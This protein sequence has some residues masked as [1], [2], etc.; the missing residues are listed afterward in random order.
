MTEPMDAPVSTKI[1]EFLANGRR[2]RQ[3]QNRLAAL[4]AF[5]AAAEIDPGDAV[6]KTELAV[7][8]HALDWLDEADAVLDSVLAAE[9][10]CVG[11]LIERGHLRRRRGDYEAAAAAFRAA[12]MA[13][14]NNKNIQVELARALR[15]LERLD[16]AGRI[17]S[18]LLNAEPRH[19][20]AL[21][22]RGHLLRKQDDQEGAAAAFAAAAATDPDNRNIAVELARALR[23]LDRIAEADAVLDRVLEAEPNN[24]GAL[25]ERAHTLR[26]R[27]DHYAAASAFEAAAAI[28]PHRNIQVELARELRAL[29]HLDAAEAALRSVVEAEPSHAGGWMELAQVCRSR[30][31]SAGMLAAL[32][33]A[34]KAAPANLDVK[35]ALASEYGNHNRADEALRVFEDILVSNPSHVATLM[36][37]GQLHRSR[38]D[39]LKAKA[40][41]RTVLEVQP[42]HTRALVE[43][44]HTSWA[45]GEPASAQALLLR[46][47]SQ[48]P[49]CLD[50]IIASAELAL[51][52]GDAASALQSARRAIELYPGQIGPYLLGARA[53]A[54]LLDRDE[55]EG[56]LDQ[57]RAAFGFRSEIAAAQ[58]HILRQY[59]CYDPVRAI[60]A[61]ADKQAPVNFGL[62]M[63]VISFAIAQGD[64]DTA[65]Q[66]LSSVSA[67]SS[68]ET[69]RVLYL[70]ASL[71][72]ARRQ[73]H[74]AVADYEAA[75]AG[76]DSEFEW[77]EAAA[78]C[79]LLLAD[80]DRA[81]DH[82]RAAMHLNAA[83]NIANGKSSNISQHH[84]GQILDEFMLH[85]ETLDMLRQASALPPRTRIDTLQ[86][87]VRDNPEQ[88]AP[89]ILLLLA[90]RQEGQFAAE[91]GPAGQ[92][93]RHAIPKR[94]VHYWHTAT[95][96]SD[97]AEIIASWRQ[98]HRDYEHVLFDDAGAINFLRAQGLDAA[99]QAFRRGATPAQRVDILRLAYLSSVGG[100]FV[101][102]D[103]RCLIP[104]DDYLPA[105]VNFAAY[106]DNYGTIGVNFLG[107]APG[108]PVITRA[109][110][111]AVT[112]VNRG[113]RDIVW[114]S[115][116]PG[117]L[118]RAFAQ[119]VVQP[120]SD[121][122]LAKCNLLE[123]WKLHSAVGV[124]CPARYK[125]L[126]SRH[127][128]L[129][130]ASV[131][132]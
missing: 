123:L 11:A 21:I 59:R 87:L 112:A 127:M 95:M 5:A 125:Q 71:A 17:L 108:H 46:A 12:A 74:E 80:T 42:S 47:L 121:D 26:R 98:M 128:K 54:D 94:I 30:D 70:R 58:I 62:C 106:Q 107:A 53:A 36:A 97:V 50:A 68:K 25:I 51:R 119:L 84:I 86:R 93:S 64:F 61:E 100:F 43:L 103:D 92:G 13:D 131:A 99:L 14:P 20:G 72:E 32:E 76:D 19:V 90:M 37:L 3:R 73:Y 15:S 91:H 60:I 67:T 132:A 28:D 57:A 24:V 130:R 111:N 52:T 118:T 27:G 85:H 89:A 129:D 65:E 38:G 23:A 2:E 10:E 101:D 35:I 31:D 7:E 69:A 126:A 8:L 56:L 117:L 114:L 79:Y 122:W 82:L 109:L 83:T 6:I 44:A 102:A 1:A 110:D 115:T 16:E 45:T 96:P 34:T 41:F 29:G 63:Q 48:D 116:G 120:G 81:R 78:R 39:A 40:A 22:E 88:T 9:P 105:S 66:S 104:L 33:A 77:H 4:A 124:H 113:D 75:I 55:A 49:T 18:D